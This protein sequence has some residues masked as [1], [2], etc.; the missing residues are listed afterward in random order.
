LC[1]ALQK[2]TIYHDE[3][4]NIEFITNLIKNINENYTITIQQIENEYKQIIDKIILNTNKVYYINL[5]HNTHGEFQCTS[6]ILSYLMDLFEPFINKILAQYGTFISLPINLD[7]E[8]LD[9]DFNSIYTKL[10]ITPLKIGN[11]NA[12]IYYSF[13]SNKNN[14]FLKII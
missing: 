13:A 5:I 1:I 8:N 7:D 3:L 2:L 6:S 12:Y 9:D 14:L 4:N 11:L 10:A